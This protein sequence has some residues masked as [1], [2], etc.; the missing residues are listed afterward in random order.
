MN[1]KTRMASALTLAGVLLSSFPA[2]ALATSPLL[3]GYGAPGAGE[4]T[5]IGSTLINGPR[6]GAGSGRSAGTG[7]SSRATQA[8]AGEGLAVGAETTPPTGAVGKSGSTGSRGS[9]GR[10]A[11]ISGRGASIGGGVRRAQRNAPRQTSAYPNKYVYS[12]SARSAA[13]SSPALGISSDDLLLLVSMLAGLGL[14]TALTKRL[15]GLQA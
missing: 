10:G 9:S 12:N 1:R 13:V 11:S 14:L 6:G 4:Q 3:S 7:G 15:A 5:I 2:P 8:S